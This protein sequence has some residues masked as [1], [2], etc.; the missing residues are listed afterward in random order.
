MPTEFGYDR[1]MR[2]QPSPAPGVASRASPPPQQIRRP[3]QIPG[4]A[5]E[6]ADLGREI[7][8]AS[9]PA[10]RS[11]RAG[12]MLPHPQSV[13]DPGQSWRA[14]PDPRRPEI[15]HWP[16]LARSSEDPGYQPPGRCSPGTGPARFQAT[17]PPAEGCHVRDSQDQPYG[18]RDRGN[19]LPPE[20][21]S[22][23]QPYTVPAGSLGPRQSSSW[24][25]GSA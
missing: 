3:C 7:V 9:Q 2:I 24:P 25:T 18:H 21:C 8:T 11:A 5:Y 14:R 22:A 16:M 17:S 12:V 6:R 19:P 4:P 23:R 13:T 1:R 20:G 15:S 10:T